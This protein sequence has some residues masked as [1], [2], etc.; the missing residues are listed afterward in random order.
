MKSQKRRVKKKR[1]R[2]S[3]GN[4]EE[5]LGGNSKGVERD[6]HRHDV[7]MLYTQMFLPKSSVKCSSR[8][9]VRVTIGNFHINNILWDIEDIGVYKTY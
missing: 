3:L 5:E 9:F 8:L 7:N 2:N 1:K 4:G 6:G